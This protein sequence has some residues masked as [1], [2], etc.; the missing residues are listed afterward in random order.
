MLCSRTSYLGSNHFTYDPERDVYICPQSRLLRRRINEYTSRKV[1]YR[2]RAEDCNICSLKVQC[3]PSNHGRVVHRHF[4]EAYLDRVRAYHETE[5]YQKAMSKRKVW[6]EPL[7]GE[8]KQ[9]HGLVRFKMRG[10]EKVNSESLLNATGQNLK[11]C[12][13]C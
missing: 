10:L 11:T 7:F 3:T 6:V 2:A 12:N 5:A 4:V 8:A 9:W 13:G 1:E